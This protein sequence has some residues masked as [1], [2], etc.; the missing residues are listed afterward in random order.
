MQIVNNIKS[1]PHVNAYP[2]QCSVYFY[3]CASVF[4]HV[5]SMAT[6]LAFMTTS[7]VSMATHLLV[8]SMEPVSFHANQVCFHANQVCFHSNQVCFHGDQRL[9]DKSLGQFAC[10][11]KQFK[12]ITILITFHMENFLKTILR[13]YIFVSLIQETFCVV[14]Y[15]K[16]S[17][18]NFGG[19]KQ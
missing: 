13:K 12:L 11:K 1:P 5:I 9:E 4:N 15:V 7:F 14:L 8:V 6:S 10:K 17:K 19:N 2:G 3:C 16:I 18:T